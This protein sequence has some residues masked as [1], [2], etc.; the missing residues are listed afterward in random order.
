MAK[1]DRLNPY[2]LCI[3]GA[4]LL[5]A[6]FLM[7]PFP[8]LVFAGLA[9]AYALADYA[10]GD[11]FWNKL[12]LVLVVLLAGFYCGYGL[13][14]GKFVPSLLQAISATLAFAA[15]SF[16]RQS[17]GSRLG[18]IPLLLFLLAL[19]YIIL[20]AGFGD[21]A[22]FLADAMRLKT[23]WVRWTSETGYLGISLWILVANHLFYLG[24]FREGLSVP[25][26]LVFL[27]IVLGPILYSYMLTT[28]GIDRHTMLLAYSGNVPAETDN[29]SLRGEWIPRTAAWVSTLILVFAF[30]KN[31]IQRK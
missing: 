28:P 31:Y 24:A 12:E 17:L 30:V 22:F 18:K 10:E 5:G 27:A 20:K 16:A 7:R 3:L 9:A 2:L 15:F 26:L 8:V 29:Y 19:E 4:M 6:G 1:K 11:F 23:D 25:W 14:G 13:A 21:Q